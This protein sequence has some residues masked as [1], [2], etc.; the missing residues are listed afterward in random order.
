MLPILRPIAE[1]IL[2]EELVRRGGAIDRGGKVV[3]TQ[4]PCGVEAANLQVESGRGA[5]RKGSQPAPQ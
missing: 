3:D 1:T 4:N 5:G 2:G